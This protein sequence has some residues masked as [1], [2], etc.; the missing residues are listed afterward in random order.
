MERIRI[1]P[2]IMVTNGD[3]GYANFLS[4]MTKKGLIRKLAPRVYSSNLVE[5]P[6][7]IIRRN[8]FLI[9]GMLFPN[10]VVSHRSAFEMRPTPQGDFF[11]TYK[12]SKKV[13]LPGLVIHLLE[14]PGSL[15]DDTRFVGGLFISCPERA[16]MEN[17]QVAYSKNDTVKC[18]PQS[19]IEERLE[20]MIRINGEANVNVLHDKARY[21]SEFLGMTEEFSKLD[22]IIGALLATKDTKVITSP[23]S[24]ARVLGEPYDPQRYDLF[25][26]LFSALNA[27]VFP[28]YPENNITAHAYRNFA[29][30]ESYFSNYIEGTEFTVDD[31]RMIIETNRPI[32]T[33]NEDSHDVLGT[34]S[35]VSDRREMSMVPATDDDLFRL[36]QSRHKTLLSARSVKH[37]GLFKMQNN[38][39]GNSYFVDYELVKGTLKKGFEFY[40]A[41]K[42]PYAKAV[43]MLFMI[44]EVHPFEDGNG[45]VSRIMMNA[46]LTHA[47]ETKIIIPTVFRIDYLNALRKLTRQSDPTVLLRAM[48]RVRFFSSKLQA[49][50][51]DS[52]KA[53]LDRANAFSDSEEDIL[54]F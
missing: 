3:K 35:I 40:Q 53:Q 36:L 17:L 30:F 8:L 46:E 32:P 15:P 28:S 48:N 31:A 26:I 41:L 51:F 12:Y 33:R 9:L 18:L 50:D 45:R 25:Q 29:F 6:E 44:S 37:P 16:M 52:M 2:E 42:S 49:D 1:L 38:R 24:K 5:T 13:K 43:F 34:F 20:K 47:N 22:K 7:V 4:S 54:R 14:G 19:D 39:A 27:E 21:L 23:L 11:M 10:A